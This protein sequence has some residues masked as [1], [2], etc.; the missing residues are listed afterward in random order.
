MKDRRRVHHWTAYLFGEIGSQELDDLGEAIRSPHVTPA[1]GL[2]R[3]H[4]SARTR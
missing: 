2:R 4:F 1:V 3:R